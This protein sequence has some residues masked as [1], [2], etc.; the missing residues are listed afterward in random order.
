MADDK[1][2]LHANH[3]QRM[4]AKYLHDGAEGFGTHELLEMLLYNSIPRE[5][6]N[7]TAHRLVDVG[8][9]YGHGLVDAEYGTLL[10]TEG[11]GEKSAFLVKMSIDTTLRLLTDKLGKAPLDDEF[12]LKMYLY[13]KLAA[14]RER[15]AIAVLLDKL[16]CV[17]SCYDLARG[18]VWRSEDVAKEVIRIVAKEKAASVVICHNHKN[19]SEEPSVEDR[20]LTSK[21]RSA[22][23][24][25]NI[26][27]IGH[28]I[29][30]DSRCIKIEL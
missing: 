5:N 21:V 24:N 27:F 29:V 7:D 10:R 28:Y 4:R 20:L 18:P 9:E 2:N 15:C 14:R 3:R 1:D 26:G 12:A 6:T 16:G 8:G 30:T 22:L 25:E 23:E 19:G 17:M 11:I 13:L